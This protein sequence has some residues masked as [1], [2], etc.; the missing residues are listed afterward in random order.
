M[1]TMMEKKK[2]KIADEFLHS[3]SKVTDP[4]RILSYL[5][6]PLFLTA[7]VGF[8]LP[9]LLVIPYSSLLP[10]FQFMPSKNHS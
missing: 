6:L 7:T 2:K 9:A 8:L 5:S 3:P 4:E 10:T 1:E